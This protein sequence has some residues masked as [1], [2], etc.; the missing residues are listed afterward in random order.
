MTPLK[1][2]IQIG[3]ELPKRSI[4]KLV[5]GSE[6]HAMTSCLNGKAFLLFH[7]PKSGKKY[8]YDVW[9][10]QNADDSFSYTGQGVKGNQKLTNS[11]LGLIKA[12]EM[13]RPI[14]FFKRP[15]LGKPRKKANPYTYIGEVTLASPSYT[16]EMAPDESGKLREVFVFKLIP[17]GA[18]MSNITSEQKI[19]IGTSEWIAS[20]TDPSI[21]EQTPRN[22]S[23]I[24]SRENKLL[25]R[26]FEY[27]T[28]KGEVAS[29]KTIKLLDHQGTLKPDFF[30]EER[31]MVVQVKPSSS[32]EYVRLAIGQVLDY[33]N[34]LRQEY[35]DITAGILLPQL[36]ASDLIQLCKQINI[37]IIAE[38]AE[39]EFSFHDQN[40]SSL[41]LDA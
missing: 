14:Y 7:D 34:L 12:Y 32:R 20:G 38:V 23:Q 13:G 8:G 16:K 17:L 39:G 24:E 41:D 27:L 21:N 28:S 19:Q 11:N 26:F 2:S 37:T 22:P 5:G 33:Q 18:T 1:F 9:E 35:Q 15:G 40:I 36:P 31:R 3:E 25:K 10:G 29:Q 4:H 30:L 6:M